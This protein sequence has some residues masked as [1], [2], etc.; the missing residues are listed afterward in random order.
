MI[1][2]IGVGR[3]L[4]LSIDGSPIGVLPENKLEFTLNGQ[5]YTVRRSGFFSRVCELLSDTAI[6]ASIRQPP[7]VQRYTIACAGREWTLKAEQTIGKRHGLFD[8]DVR[9]GSITPS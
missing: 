5:T 3:A 7:F 2:G 4:H 9:V 8:G 6:L 1:K